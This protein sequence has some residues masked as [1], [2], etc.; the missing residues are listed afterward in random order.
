[1]LRGVELEAR[2]GGSAATAVA[3][4]ISGEPTGVTGKW[5]DPQLDD[6]KWETVAAGAVS[7]DPPAAAGLIWYRMKFDLPAADPHVWVP[8]DLQLSAK[9]NGFI[10]FNGHFIGRWW[11]NG[12]QRNFYL[13]DCWLRRGPSSR[14]I[15]ALCLWPADSAS[16]NSAAVVPQADV[17]ESR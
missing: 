7:M 2:A 8:W 17:A 13:P 12:P 9:G 15:V 4:E 10:Y 11:Q 1:M 16:L 6:S 14:N 5:W 3:C